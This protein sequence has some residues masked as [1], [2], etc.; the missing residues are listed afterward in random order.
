MNKVILVIKIVG[1]LWGSIIALI[2]QAEELMPEQGQ[3]QQ[4]LAIVRAALEAAFGTFKDLEVKFEEVWPTLAAMIASVVA[5]FN[6]R[7]VFKKGPD[8]PE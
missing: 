1:A 4:K 3:G 6:S 8:A 2:K 5:V 7:G